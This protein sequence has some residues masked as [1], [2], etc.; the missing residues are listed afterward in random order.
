MHVTYCPI[1]VGVHAVFSIWGGQVKAW[2][3]GFFFLIVCLLLDIILIYLLFETAHKTNL[4]GQTSS[5][6]SECVDLGPVVAILPTTPTA[7]TPILGPFCFS[8]SYPLTNFWQRYK[9]KDTLA[10]FCLLFLTRSFSLQSLVCLPLTHS[11]SISPK[12]TPSP[13]PF[14][15]AT[16]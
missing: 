11:P 6:L 13:Y 4:E 3:I 5:N 8:H 14:N 16:R 10:F 7:T 15:N 2:Q 9:K 1:S 12:T